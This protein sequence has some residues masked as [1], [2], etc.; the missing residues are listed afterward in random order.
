MNAIKIE[1][2]SSIPVNGSLIGLFVGKKVE[3]SGKIVENRQGNCFV[4][5]A[6]V[7]W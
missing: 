5:E 4:V 3:L 7:S 2:S 6:A 1:G